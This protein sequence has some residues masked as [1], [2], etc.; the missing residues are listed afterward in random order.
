MITSRARAFTLLITAFVAGGIVGG[1]GLVALARNGKAD[2]V[3]RGG[4]GGPDRGFPMSRKHSDYLA[5][6]LKI[7]VDAVAADSI[8]AIYCRRVVGIDSLLAQVQEQ[9]RPMME[10]MYRMSD[11][12]FAL[13]RPEVERRRTQSR[14]AIRALLTPPQQERYDSMIRVDDA[15]RRKQRESG[16]RPFRGEGPCYPDSGRNG[17]RDG[18]GPRGPR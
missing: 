8:N 6:E 12:L 14:E 7:S 18:G 11:S 13:I 3:F 17:G 15:N 2:F 10:T 16:P 9:S 1:A 4:R 5:R